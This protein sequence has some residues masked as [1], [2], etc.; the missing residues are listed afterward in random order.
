MFFSGCFSP[1]NSTHGLNS[2]SQMIILLAIW[3][4]LLDSVNITG[5][6]VRSLAQ[7]ALILFRFLCK[8]V[9]PECLG[10]FDIAASRFFESLFG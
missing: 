3:K 6:Y 8:K 5:T 4:K 1:F 2:K 7:V 10:S 9:A